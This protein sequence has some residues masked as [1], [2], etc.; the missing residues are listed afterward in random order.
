M[1]CAAFL[2]HELTWNDA[3]GSFGQQR[4]MLFLFFVDKAEEYR[5]QEVEPPEVHI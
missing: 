2:V 3:T 5:L 4:I 1:H